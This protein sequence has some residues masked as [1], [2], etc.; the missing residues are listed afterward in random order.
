MEVE[1]NGDH[2]IFP[3][4][5][6]GIKL[7][8]WD[9]RRS[10]RGV[11]FLSAYFCSRREALALARGPFWIRVWDKTMSGSGLGRREKISGIQ[12]R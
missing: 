9:F 2:N 3:A 7:E 12:E 5:G 8:V 11:G 6:L 1:Q 10:R 4:S